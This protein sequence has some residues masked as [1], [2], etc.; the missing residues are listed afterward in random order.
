MQT[1]HLVIPVTTAALLFGAA[2]PTFAIGDG[3]GGWVDVDEDG[4]EV[5][6]G[7]IDGGTDEASP[8]PGS[9][10]CSWERLT[11]SVVEGIWQ[12]LDPAEQPTDVTAYEWYWVT[13][14]DETGGE[15]TD[16]V[17]VPVP[18]PTPVDPT[19]LRDEA[20][21][22]LV[23]PG[24]TIGTSPSG[25]QIVH[26]ETWLWIDGAIW[27]PHE[28]SATAGAVTATVTAAP[29]RVAWDL[30]NGD[31]IVCNGPGSPYDP[32]TAAEDQTTDCSYTYTSSSAGRP[33]DAYQ[34]S[35]TVEW[36]V[37]WTV[38]GAAGGGALPALFTSAP[39]TVRVAELQALNQ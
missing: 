37:R 17:P 34:L 6:V 26:V 18:D 36:S 2:A 24:P 16:L 8:G 4:S 14:P 7:A 38:S 31:T 12:Q 39:T 21:D 32:A 9:S 35:A 27:Q 29:S 22:T 15:Y 10:S 30:G 28:Q 11:T 19:I 23:L 25:D 20:V 3:P 13:C 33:G 1:R 5:D